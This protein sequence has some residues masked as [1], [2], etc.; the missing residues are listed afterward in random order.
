MVVCREASA[1]VGDLAWV[2]RLRKVALSAHA[3]SAVVAKLANSVLV[4][5]VY[6]FLN[7]KNEPV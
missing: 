4:L 6:T 1:P 3:A 7:R 2:R 5:H